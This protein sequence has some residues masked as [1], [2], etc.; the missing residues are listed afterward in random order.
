MQIK[1]KRSIEHAA[2]RELRLCV[3]SP[4]SGSPQHICPLSLLRKH[5]ARAGSP[6]TVYVC[7]GSEQALDRLVVLMHERVQSVEGITTPGGR[8]YFAVGQ[9]SDRNAQYIREASRV[10][11]DRT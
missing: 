3:E 10:I 9:V 5:G 8:I 4:W 11:Y 2:R 1:G 6:L 7:V